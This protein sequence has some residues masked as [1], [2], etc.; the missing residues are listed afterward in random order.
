MCL[1]ITRDV[2]LMRQ[3]KMPAGKI[4]E[5]IDARYGS[6]GPGTATPPPP[7]R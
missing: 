4:R 5:A 1:D 7:G 3:Q 6:R 2:M